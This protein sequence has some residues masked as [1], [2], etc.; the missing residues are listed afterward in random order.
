[1][2]ARSH[3]LGDDRT[4]ARPPIRI[5]HLEDSRTDAQ[6]ISD[7][8]DADDLH[9]QIVHA[10]DRRGFETALSGGSFDIILCDNNLP[11]YSAFSA[12][13]ATNRIS[14]LTPLLIISGSIGEDEAVRGL[15]MG[16][17]DYLLKG[18]L[19]RLGSAVRRALQE[20]E[21]RRRRKRAEDELRE[22]EE[23][24]RLALAATND[25]IW[26]LDLAHDT[27]VCNQ[28][29]VTLFGQPP[30][31]APRQWM[32][33]IVHA[34]D[35][36]RVRASLLAAIENRKDF[37][38]EA[39]R[40]RRSDGGWAHVQ[41][42]ACLAKSPDGATN[43][44]IGAI[45]DVTAAIEAEGKRQAL[46]EQLRQSQKLEAIGTLAGGIAHD[47]NNIL[48]IILTNA[49]VAHACVTVE[50]GDPATVEEC[51]AEI[52]MASDRAR[53]LVRQI[54]TFSRRSEAERTI[55]EPRRIVE[56]CVRMLRSTLPA[57]VTLVARLPSRTASILANSNQLHQ[58]LLN[59]STNSWHALPEGGGHI[60]LSVEDSR[61]GPGV[62]TAGVKIPEGD[63][64]RISVADDGHGMSPDVIGR[65]FEPFF[66]TKPV[67]RGTGLGL[68][69]VHGIVTAHQGHILVDSAPG[70]GTRIDMLFPAVQAADS[71]QARPESE[72]P[73]GN[74]QAIMIVEDDRALARANRR[75]LER[76]GYMVEVFH[77]PAAALEA[78]ECDPERAQL[79]ITDYSMPG[80]TGIEFSH[81]VMKICPGLPVVLLTGMT[82]AGP[83]SGPR[84][85]NIKSI[86]D[87]PVSPE[88]LCQ[89]VDEQLSR[90]GA[91]DA[92]RTR[93]LVVDDDRAH[94]DACVRLLKLEGFE[95]LTAS[96]GVE[97]LKVIDKQDVDLVLTD[98]LM[99]DMEGIE[100][101]SRLR[102]AKPGLRMIS[103][104]GGGRIGAVQCLDLSR[105]FGV[106][107]TLGK[108]FS[109]DELLA[110]IHNALLR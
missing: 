76:N 46:E 90:N 68:A 78:L 2:D 62:I 36:E 87:K 47:F 32:I 98:I 105:R 53:D 38:S 57:M 106:L 86:F 27:M 97:A 71:P 24:M 80:M 39:F 37:W 55:V 77:A 85:A 41:N 19:E 33:E 12:I 6:L 16:A 31:G 83:R 88:A 17:K 92:C 101:I 21:E 58:V 102:K 3:S 5:L 14:P 67:G 44:I 8:L 59:L 25:A 11:D 103:M 4:G 104:S 89:I 13:E 42:R 84:P 81:R 52:L 69:V 60:T 22:N 23:R 66:T 28:A 49:E 99:P 79:L 30:A 50:K 43:R 70:R 15:Q 40:M 110:A 18:R 9:C 29:F 56:E 10:V 63:Y 93:V 74:G 107:Q 72:L 61:V 1:M 65:M 54:L 34:E 82:E 109:R 100:L 108:P 94:L 20:A 35:R 26:D 73:R 91:N 7:L 96:N 51:L 48:G 64:V 45:Q 95:T 75:V